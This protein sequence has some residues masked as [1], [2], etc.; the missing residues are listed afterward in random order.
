MRWISQA[1]VLALIRERVGPMSDAA[2]Y[3]S[4]RPIMQKC[5]AWPPQGKY[6]FRSELGNWMV[7]LE[8]RKNLIDA[9]EWKSSRPYSTQDYDDIV[10]GGLYEEYQP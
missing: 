2:F 10:S 1:D 7:Y 9:G 8:T 5:E 6:M 4:L 3:K